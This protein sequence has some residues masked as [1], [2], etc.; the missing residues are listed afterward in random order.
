MPHLQLRH[1]FAFSLLVTALCHR[2]AQAMGVSF[3]L[4]AAPSPMASETPAKGQ[5]GPQSIASKPEN[6]PLA[7]VPTHRPLPIPIQAS[8]P[9][10]R[11]VQSKQTLPANV[12]ASTRILAPPPLEALPSTR[13]I[14]PSNSPLTAPIEVAQDD[15]GLSF[16]PTNAAAVAPIPA[17][18]AASEPSPT[19][20]PW[21]YKGGSDSLVAR[22]IGSAEGTRTP[23]GQPTRAYYGHTDPGN[24][25]WNMGTFSYQH[26]ASSP[27][28]AD[29]KQLK[30]LQ[31]Q[32]KTLEQQATQADL[33]MS[34]GEVLNALDLANQSPRAAL[35]RGGYIDRLAQAR[36]KGLKNDRAIVW[37][38]THAYLDPE[39]QRWNAPGLGNT[40]SSIQRDQNRRHQA[41]TQA[42]EH[43]QAQRDITDK[44]PIDS[45]DTTAVAIA[46]PSSQPLPVSKKPQAEETDK[47]SPLSPQ[48]AAIEFN[49]ADITPHDS[50]IEPVAVTPIPDTELS[51]APTPVTKE[52][53]Q[54]KVILQTDDIKI[55]S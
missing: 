6:P 55:R 52:R 22:V 42:F 13:I 5:E 38:R 51:Q 48:M 49:V 18:T 45:L 26:G 50:Q 54:A 17:Q 15:V 33:S 4:T 14:P 44:P 32:G 28:E 24:G 9:P 34:L 39:T 23:S 12:I 53:P 11:A 30:R 21:I 37:A 16:T 3:D 35:E 19:L 40:L 46:P 27:K 20:P 10:T 41:I 25:V 31:R 47:G 1:L 7:E 2:P 29:S 36:Q 8:Q 43:Y